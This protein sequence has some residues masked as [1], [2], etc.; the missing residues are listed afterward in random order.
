MAQPATETKIP[1]NETTAETPAAA[2][3]PPTMEDFVPVPM[4]EIVTQDVIESI[5]KGVDTDL[6]L[7]DFTAVPGTEIGDNY[8]SVMYAVDIEAKSRKTSETQKI[9]TMLK[10]MPRHPMRQQMIVEFQAF[11]REQKMYDEILPAFLKFQKQHGISDQELFT[12]YPKCY[13]TFCDGKS[14]YLALENLR[15]SG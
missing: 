3:A 8:M 12:Q 10:T 2:V 13:S 7:V 1:E 4:E 15:F 9:R 5:V 6:E 11:V 14:D